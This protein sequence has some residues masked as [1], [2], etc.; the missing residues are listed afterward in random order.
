MKPPHVDP[1]QLLRRLL[2]PLA[3]DWKEHIHIGDRVRLK[4][5]SLLLPVI[6]AGA[7]GRVTRFD[8]Q[9]AERGRPYE[10]EFDLRSYDLKQ[11][12]FVPEDLLVSWG[13]DPEEPLTH[14]WTYLGPGDLEVAP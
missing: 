9:M 12:D 13:V 3:S 11:R 14:L 7:P 1:A 10:V 6:P 8:E 4:R 2:S 5:Q